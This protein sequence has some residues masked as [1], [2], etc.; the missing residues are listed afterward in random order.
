MATFSKQ[1]RL[2]SQKRIDQ[3]FA[4]GNRMMVHPFSVHWQLCDSDALPQ[5]AQVLITTSKRK[6]R[7]AVDRNRVKRL[8]R[9]CYRAHKTDLYDT[10]LSH[11]RGLLLSIN[12]IHH[13]LPC[14]ASLNARMAKLIAQLRQQIDRT[15]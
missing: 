4:E 1:E 6:F 14:Y 5:P 11:H 8:T 9:E 10:L 12:Y 3:L 2:C 7:H 13:E 15:T